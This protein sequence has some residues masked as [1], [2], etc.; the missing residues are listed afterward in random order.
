MKTRTLL[1]PEDLIII[2]QTEAYRD[3][4]SVQEW[5]ENLLEKE[6]IN[7]GHNILTKE[8]R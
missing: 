7:R 4:M 1:F 6:M 5:I 8:M 3:G 2:V